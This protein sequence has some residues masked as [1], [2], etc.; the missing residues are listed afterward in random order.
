M[1]QGMKR[2][3]RSDPSYS[4]IEVRMTKNYFLVWAHGRV[5]DFLY[6]NPYGHPS[7]DRI[8][9]DEHYE[10]ENMRIIDLDENRILSRFI[11][12]YLRLAKYE[13]DEQ[14]SRV[15]ARNIVATCQHAGLNPKRLI[16]FL[17]NEI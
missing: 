1:W 15:L 8:D 16:D 6:F 12:S 11:A 2:R 5:S 3:C 9:A 13:G 10:P 7:V 14:K 17:R 4:G